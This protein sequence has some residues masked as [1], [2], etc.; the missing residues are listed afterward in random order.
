M[1]KMKINIKNMSKIVL[2]IILIILIMPVY[3]S[4]DD[5]DSMQSQID[6]W[7]NYG[8]N[9]PMIDEQDIADILKPIAQI[10]LSIATGVV[11]I[12]ASIMGIKYMT[13]SPE[14]QAKLK[15]QLIGLVIAIIVIYGA[16]GIWAIAYRFMEDLI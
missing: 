8:K 6:R 4:A 2:I 15:T 13:A 5:F 14:G 7:E 1:I 10:L 3:V 11:V 16:Y 12:T 9:N